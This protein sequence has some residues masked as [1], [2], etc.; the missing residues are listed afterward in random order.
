M[1]KLKIA[2]N[3]ALPIANALIFGPKGTA[4]IS[5]VVDSGSSIT[6][7]DR[8]VLSSIGFCA[9]NRIGIINIK[10]VAGPSARGDIYLVKTLSF[11]GKNLRNIEAAS[12][13]FSEWAAHGIN[14]LIGFDLI[15][16]LDFEFYGS[17]GFLTLY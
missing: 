4:R 9:S 1:R 7:V 11:W 13:N 14:G 2:P 6:Q 17:R 10:G 8:L 15:R 12:C 3:V 5:L 16:T